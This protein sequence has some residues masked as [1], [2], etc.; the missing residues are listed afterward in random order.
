M[1][2]ISTLFAQGKWDIILDKYLSRINSI[3]IT[4]NLK[5]C[6][7]N[8]DLL[9]YL[10]AACEQRG[11][12]CDYLNVLKK[13]YKIYPTDFKNG[14]Q[15]RVIGITNFALEALIYC[16]FNNESE[17]LGIE[18]NI[19]DHINKVIDFQDSLVK[20]YGLDY[21]KPQIDLRLL[22][23]DYKNNRI[24]IYTVEYLYPFEP[25]VKD[26][27]FDLSP[28]YPYI[29]L[30][31]KK[32]PRDIDNYT[33][34]KFKA[35]GLIKPDSWWKGPKWESHEKMPPVKKSLPIVNM[36]LLQA[37]KA[38][39][40][41]MVLPYSIEQVSTASMFQYRWDENEPILG[42]TTTSTDFQ[43]QWVGGNS[44]WH[45]FTDDEM[46]KLNQ[47]IID[48]YNNKPFVTTFHHANNL[49]SAG[50]NLEGFLL[51]CSSCE[52]MAYHW[53][54][55]I[56]K[57]CG[58]LEEYVGFSQTKISKCDTCGFFTLSNAKKP[59]EGM[60]PTLFAIFSF[61][62]EHQCI[63]KREKNQLNKYISKV[64]N[65]ELRNKTTH[66]LND[67]VNKKNADESL[68]AIFDLQNLFVDIVNR[69]MKEKH[70]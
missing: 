70:L 65:E 10:L 68:N 19:E 21:D 26:Y 60:E 31:V 69:I 23:D 40:G 62:F 6:K 2:D 58:I 66:G 1:E 27:V 51:L 22:F 30:E 32:S 4:N 29:S 43:A 34:F 13:Y 52:G 37:V 11:C 49:L 63:T 45:E 55:K 53:C 35:Y 3:H 9:Y 47:S 64:R 42:G 61:L 46:L 54:E 24:P 59:Y 18:Y 25:I 67:N 7:E 8:I 28:C 36:L 15:S 39:P 56:A 48:T 20:K 12:Y 33:I 5:K 16:L 57:L 38:S 50:F 17:N 14:S 41:K 44:L